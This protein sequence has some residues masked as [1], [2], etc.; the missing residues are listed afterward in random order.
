MGKETN[1]FFYM[2]ILKMVAIITSVDI[3]SKMRMEKLN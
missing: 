1:T 3:I 2:T